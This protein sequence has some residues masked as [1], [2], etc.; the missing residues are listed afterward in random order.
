MICMCT[1]APVQSYYQLSFITF[2]LNRKIQAFLGYY[3]VFF[4][5]VDE[6]NQRLDVAR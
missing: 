5:K 1:Y 2:I 4:Y 6:A 3:T